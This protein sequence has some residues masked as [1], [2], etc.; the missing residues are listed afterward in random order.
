[1]V[2]ATTPLTSPTGSDLVFFSSGNDVV[3]LTNVN[4]STTT[5]PDT[6][7]GMA[8]GDKLDLSGLLGSGSV[9]A[10]DGFS[11]PSGPGFI[12]IKNLAINSR[13]VSGAVSTTSNYV[14]FDVFFDA[15]LYA[16]KQI[17]GAKIDLGYDY[18]KVSAM[19][20]TGNSGADLGAS[21]WT[22]ITSNPANGQFVTPI[23]SDLLDTTKGLDASQIID[24][25]GKAFHV[26]LT[27]NT[28]VTNFA[29]AL[30]SK[31]SGGDTYLTT[32]DGTQY[33]DVNGPKFVTTAGGKTLNLVSDSNSQKTNETFT[34]V[35]DNELHFLEVLDGSSGKGRL[36]FKYDTNSATGTTSVSDV[37]RV[38]FVG[39]S[40]DALNT[41]LA[42]EYTKVL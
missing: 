1:L 33:V 23:N 34:T 10:Y 25:N 28:V 26:R 27:T 8:V 31:A 6:L 35:G 9:S 36:L 3:K 11:T 32:A 21:T 19:L 17:T 29:V 37:V 14:E 5:A 18:S 12:E 15:S 22:N 40:L 39:S 41:F 38:D 16:T 42:S 24:A 30:E 2:T 7:V 4:Q 20:V 13:T